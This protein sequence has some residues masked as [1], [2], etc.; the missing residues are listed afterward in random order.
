MRYEKLKEANRNF[1]KFTLRLQELQFDIREY[2]IDIITVVHK[3]TNR[4]QLKIKSLEEL[5]IKYLDKEIMY[6]ILS[7]DSKKIKYPGDGIKTAK[8]IVYGIQKLF[9]EHQKIYTE[10]YFE[11]KTILLQS[12]ELGKN[13]HSK[14]VDLSVSEL[15]VLYNESKD[16]DILNLR[17]STLTE[18]LK[19]LVQ[20]DQE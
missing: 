17:L 2:M 4:Q 19:V 16:A 1:D 13:I 12:K 5:E 7:I 20:T 15:Q 3:N 18:R 8:E 14:Q 9:T 6:A 10:N 11:I